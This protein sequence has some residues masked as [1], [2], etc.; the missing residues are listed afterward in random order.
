MLAGLL[1]AMVLA[2][3]TIDTPPNALN[4]EAALAPA[5][6]DLAARLI[7][8]DPAMDRETLFRR[9]LPAIFNFTIY[10]EGAEGHHDRRAG[11]A[12]TRRAD[13]RV[14][15]ERARAS[16]AGHPVLSV[17]KEVR[18][19]ISYGTGKDVSAETGGSYLELPA[20]R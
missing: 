17:I 12:R 3:R 10:A 15:H 1:C 2:A 7:A 16:Y 18:R 13:G 8:A 5:M 9:R 20:A 4:D 14:L 19:Q 11:R 6:P